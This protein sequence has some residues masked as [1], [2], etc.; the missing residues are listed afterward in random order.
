VAPLR[1]FF[2]CFSTVD[3]PHFGGFSG[4]PAFPNQRALSLRAVRPFVGW[5][6]RNGPYLLLFF[7]CA[8]RGLVPLKRALFYARVPPLVGRP[9]ALAGSKEESL[10]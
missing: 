7:P 2:L 6:G 5:N 10:L 9:S 1:R 4:M 3:D 8:A